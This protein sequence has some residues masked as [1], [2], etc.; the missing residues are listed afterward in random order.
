MSRG[1]ALLALLAMGA[2]WGM[3]IPLTK[4]A[5]S[6]GY[7]HFGLIFWQMVIGVVILG[8]VLVVRGRLPLRPTRVQV[9]VWLL[10]AVIGTI[11]PNSASYQAAFHLPAGIM[12]IA[13]S[14]VPMFAFPIALI[15]GADRF[16]WTRM[17]GLLCGLA[18]VVI[19]SAP[20]LTL[21]AAA[22]SLWV[23]VALIAPFFYGIEGNV[24]AKY[25]TAGLDPVQVLFGA[26]ALGAV[27][28][29]PL[30]LISGQWIDPR[31]PYD[32]ADLGLLL[33]SS[34]HAVVYAGYVALVGRAGAVF[35][36][37]VAY[38]V[39]AFGV[40]WSM[41]ILGERYTGGLWIALAVMM[42]GLFLVQPREVRRG[43]VG[44]GA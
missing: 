34:I 27:L 19:L 40:I 36:A 9:G 38:L 23:L 25:G 37:Q 13:I 12:A 24:V 7:G 30:A 14:T 16:G 44:A 29:L 39:T 11:I 35:S 17:T 31:P 42:L 33:T 26:S 18:G 8:A 2:G 5:V 43:L 32:I 22:L 6:T 15:L 3:T 21:S 4:L 1:A 20:G 41:L 28:V 10:I